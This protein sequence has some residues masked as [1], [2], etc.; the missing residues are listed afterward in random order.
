MPN[1]K[2]K[3]FLAREA[4][5]TSL[6][7]YLFHCLHEMLRLSKLRQ[8]NKSEQLGYNL[9]PK[10][11]RL[12]KYVAPG[13]TLCNGKWGNVIFRD[14]WRLLPCT[15]D[16][17]K[18]IHKHALFS[19]QIWRYL[20]L[21]LH[22]RM[23]TEHTSQ[24]LGDSQGPS[25]VELPSSIVTQT[26]V[27]SLTLEAKQRH[28]MTGHQRLGLDGEGLFGLWAEHQLYADMFHVLSSSWVS[29]LLGRTIMSCESD[30]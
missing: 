10:P 14:Q 17:S 1:M 25:S 13:C 11:E 15:D 21:Q 27:S 4:E 7:C 2:G 30:W 24:V 9:L 26:R 5:R 16:W 3:V 6:L 18:A 23:G 29:L 22:F 20:C 12:E 28:S 19:C 8:H